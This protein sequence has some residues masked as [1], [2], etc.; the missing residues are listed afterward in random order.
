MSSSTTTL[1]GIAGRQIE[2]PTG[3]FINNEFVPSTS[4]NTLETLNPS[5]GKLLA[6]V[7]A[8]EEDDINIAV[9]AAEAAYK[10]SWGSLPGTARRTLLLKLA[11][12]IERDA[13]DFATI[14][15]LDA[16]ILFGDSKNINIASAVE[17]LRY[18]A[19]WADKID[20]R[21]T[22]IP[23]G[24]AYT[25]REPI[26][27]CGVIVPW[28]APLMITSWKLAPCL[29]VGN[30]IVLK[31]AELT[32]LYGLK[33]A[34]LVKEAGFPPGVINILTGYG[35]KAGQALAEHM[36]VRKLAFTGSGPVGRG[37]LIA[38]AKSNLKKVTLELGG[39]GASI[40]FDDADLQN[41]VLWAIIGITTHNGQLCAAGSRLYIQ[42][43]IYDRFVEAFRKS[44]IA[45]V[46][47]DPL[48]GQTTKGPLIS[49][50]QKNTVLKYIQNGLS[51][52]AKLLHGGKEIALEG[53]YIE[54]TAFVEAV[55]NMSIM[56]E[57]IFG[58]VASLVKF[59]TE[60]EAIR[61]ANDSVYGL[62]S[63]IFTS[64]ISRAQRVS[65]SLESGQ[66]TINSW[67]NINSNTPFGGVK[68]SGFGRDLGEESLDGWTNLKSVKISVLA[69]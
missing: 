1:I 51:E 32:P 10:G 60:E 5:N 29:A 50:T 2:L 57:E 42:E 27:V 4:G 8:A 62:S 67:G 36:D 46:A 52:G 48:H 25:R 47:G 63:A 49:S 9:R 14:E 41:A 30:V 34:Q 21:S 59:K 56:K 54:N 20:G 17:A 40:I 39:K 69:E 13:D 23:N 6:T 64:D 15:A 24:M 61:R 35:A 55:E 44:S 43:G 58:P 28:N 12:L 33:L 68:Q 38:S 26:G 37:I 66:V 45:A 22:Q 53:H 3:L 7:S 31:T 11:D 18:F 19:G 65:N 16:G